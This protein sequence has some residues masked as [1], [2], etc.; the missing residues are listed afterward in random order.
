MAKV[1]ITGG[2]GLV[3]RYLCNALQ[4]RG[5]EVSILSRTGKNGNEIPAYTWNWNRNEIEEEAI[6]TA[7]YIVHLAGVNIGE[8]RWTAKRKQQILDSRVRTA[9][10]IFNKTE[11]QN[12]RLKAFIS[13][14]AIGYYGARTTEEIYNETDPPSDDFLGQTC[15]RW[16]QVADRFSDIG[17]R[18]V[19]IRTGIV[20][21]KHGG[22]LQKFNLPSRLGIGIIIGK[23]KQYF[24]WIHIQDLCNIYIAAIE[25]IQMV[26]AYNA[27]APEH[28]TYSQFIRKL[29]RHLSKPFWFPKIPS[30]VLQ[31][32]I[33][34]KAE[35]ILYGSRISSDRM[36]AAG[37]EFSF[38]DLDSALKQLYS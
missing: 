18:S 25:N 21:S 15:S 28:L 16:E 27:V 5:Y 11:G 33:G 30:M 20:L 6:N 7:D 24:P 8:K 38:P 19:K 31:I 9:E 36:R 14:S 29:T 34:K 10:L 35:M 3:G 13:A 2:T 23:G 22:V 32:I 26:G 17:I 1:L 37:Y 4:A 12:K